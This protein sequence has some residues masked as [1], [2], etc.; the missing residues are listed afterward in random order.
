MK[1]MVAGCCFCEK[2]RGDLGPEGGVGL[3]YDPHLYFARHSLYAEDFQV[4][5]TYCPSCLT[6][7]HQTSARE[8]GAEVT[9]ASHRRPSYQT[10]NCFLS[11]K[12]FPGTN[13]TRK[14]WP[15]ISRPE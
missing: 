10:D 2:I 1:P 9:G 12:V 3:W 5:Q 11:R 13:R 14:T 4:S 7:Y 6:K 8:K 15:A